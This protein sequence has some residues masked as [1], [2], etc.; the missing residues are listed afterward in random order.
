MFIRVVGRSLAI[1]W[2]FNPG[3]RRNI[4]GRLSHRINGANTRGIIANQP[5]VLAGLR[6]IIIAANSG[7]ASFGFAM[8]FNLRWSRLCRCAGVL[9]GI[10]QEH[11]SGSSQR[12]EKLFLVSRLRRRCPL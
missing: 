10:E 6:S 11:N 7:L 8:R 2:R 5:A 3:T 1:S 9:P 12:G 4:G